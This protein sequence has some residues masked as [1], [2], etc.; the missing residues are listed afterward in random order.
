MKGNRANATCLILAAGNSSRLGFPKQSVLFQGVPLLKH[1]VTTAIKAGCDPVYVV[2]G[3]NY[4]GDLEILSNIIYHHLINKQWEKGIGNSIRFGVK[5]IL[6]GNP[7][8]PSIILMVCDQPYLT[9]EHLTKMIEFSTDP[10]IEVVGSKYNDTLGTPVLFKSAFFPLL[11]SMQDNMG[12]K[13]LLNKSNPS[14]KFIELENGEIDIDT[15]EDIENLK[16][17]K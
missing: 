3:A 10:S 12:A 16:L 7:D 2:S 13:K 4:E 9:S 11:M 1:A 15:K 8:C 14:M 6:S 17:Q 5:E